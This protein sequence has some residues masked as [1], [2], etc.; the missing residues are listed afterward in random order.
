MED[1]DIV[2]EARQDPE[3]KR[4]IA[5]RVAMQETELRS[6]RLDLFL[7]ISSVVLS[8]YW[9]HS[10]ANWLGVMIIA[11]SL[12]LL[13]IAWAFYLQ[14]LMPLSRSASFVFL[15]SSLALVSFTSLLDG[16]LYAGALYI[17]PI[18]TMAAAFLLGK[19]WSVS[20]AALSLGVIAFNSWMIKAYPI[21]SIFPETTLDQVLFRLAMLG[22]L[23]GLA[24]SSARMVGRTLE[25]IRQRKL[26]TQEATLAAQDAEKTKQAFLANMSHE[27]RTPLHGIIGLTAQ[28]ERPGREP[29]NAAAIA[30]MRDCA[31]ELLGLLND[32]LDL[33]KVEAGKARLRNQAF[34]VGDLV[35]RLAQTYAPKVE[36]KGLR[37]ALSASDEELWLSGD[38]ARLGQILTNLLDNALQHSH[39]GSV[40][41]N[42]RDVAL[43][44]G[45]VRLELSVQDQGAGI[46]KE[47]LKTLQ[48]RFAS[49]T[50]IVQEPTQ[51]E[52]LGLGLVLCDRLVRLMNGRLSI[53]SQVGQGTCVSLFVPLDRA[54]AQRRTRLDETTLAGLRILVVDDSQINQ[55]VAK[56]HL[57]HLQIGADLA[58]DAKSAI[59]MC[60]TTQYDLVMLDLRMP[61]ID[62]VQAAA[63]IREIEGYA[64]L[65]MVASTAAMDE[66]WERRCKDVGIHQY[67]IKPFHPD[68]LRACLFKCFAGGVARRESESFDKAL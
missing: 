44:Q 67:L 39:T 6:A 60:K 29:K 17:L 12:A 66:E 8:V 50:P 19:A 49:P 63:R 52:S 10:V 26:E 1:A 30:T 22:M 2:A 65:P 48:T 55:R 32:V 3:F 31:Q 45:R 35:E 62:G 20:F 41:L 61:E 23:S 36:Q 37:W 28:L 53:E 9:I 14:K 15:F 54:P 40:H 59:E 24:I 51:G 33:S 46:S 27:I 16:Q 56:L 11:N 42:V 7:K 25:S 64:R 47:Y 38:E 58:S 5:A 68:S 21:V 13:S 43:D 4:L 18:P 57:S 34:C